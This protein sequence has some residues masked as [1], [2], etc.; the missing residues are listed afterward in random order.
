M[1]IILI[2]QLNRRPFVS[3]PFTSSSSPQAVGGANDCVCLGARQEMLIIQKYQT[4]YVFILC[5]DTPVRM[6][7]NV[8]I[9]KML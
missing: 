8:D 6:A 9:K 5:L 7:I 1:L 4:N 2:S 3:L